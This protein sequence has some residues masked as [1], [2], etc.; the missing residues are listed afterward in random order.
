MYGREGKG[1]CGSFEAFWDGVINGIK[2]I[3]IMYRCRNI[4]LYDILLR[5]E[6]NAGFGISEAGIF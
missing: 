5:F 6:V 3:E 1:D 2:L 4:M